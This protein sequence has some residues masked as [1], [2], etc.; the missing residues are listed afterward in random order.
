MGSSGSRR[1]E[2]RAGNSGPSGMSA[3]DPQT[4]AE[5]TPC[6][7]PFPKR[8]HRLQFSWLGFACDY[9]I[10]CFGGGGVYVDY[11]ERRDEARCLCKVGLASFSDSIGDLRFRKKYV[12]VRFSL[13]NVGNCDPCTSTLVK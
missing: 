2:S 9:G 1:R 10:D 6:P 4:R 3:T 8:N 11:R 13:A 5:T 12:R 7:S